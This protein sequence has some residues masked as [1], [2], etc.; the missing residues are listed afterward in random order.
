MEQSKIIDT[1]ETYQTIF[2]IAI[3][4]HLIVSKFLQLNPSQGSN[5]VP[6]VSPPTP[7]GA[8]GVANVMMAPPCQ[9]PSPSSVHVSTPSTK[10]V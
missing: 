3:C 7:S 9:P 5:N 6:A 4:I 10:T 8:V 1:L 2:D